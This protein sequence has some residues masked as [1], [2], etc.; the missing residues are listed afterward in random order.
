MLNREEG[1]ESESESESGCRI[2]E[3]VLK[4][5]VKVNRGVGV[6]SGSGC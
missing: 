6:E 4:M 3:W 2:G 5:E 1:V